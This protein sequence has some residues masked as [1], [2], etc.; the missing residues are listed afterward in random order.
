MLPS[1]LS[2]Q[3]GLI[4]AS[5]TQVSG[6]NDSICMQVLDD[7]TD[8]ITRDLVDNKIVEWLANGVDIE[9]LRRT[10]RA[11]YK[12]GALKEVRPMHESAKYCCLP[13]CNC[14]STMQSGVELAGNMC[15]AL[16]R[17]VKPFAMLAAETGVSTFCAAE[18]HMHTYYTNKYPLGCL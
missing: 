15:N 14:A 1:L 18:I 12:A 17:A 3:Q 10:N 11:G 9:V 7:S 5:N 4:L 13:V 16:Q 2:S 6:R 8:H